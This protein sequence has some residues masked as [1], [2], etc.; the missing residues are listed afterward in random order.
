MRNIWEFISTAKI[1][2]LPPDTLNQTLLRAESCHL[3]CNPPCTLVTHV[4]LKFE[5]IPEV[6]PSLSW[7]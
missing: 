7:W 1:L 6:T 3:F 2:G 5:K 4:Y